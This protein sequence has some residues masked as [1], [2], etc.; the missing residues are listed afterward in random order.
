MIISSSAIADIIKCIA[1]KHPLETGG[2]LI[3]HY[4]TRFCLATVEVAS[5]PPPDSI[6][7]RYSF[8]RG[9]QGLEALLKKQKKKKHYYLGEW[10]SHPNHAPSASATDIWQMNKFATK[11]MYGS[12]S[13]LLLIVGGNLKNGLQWQA[14]LH[15]RWRLPNYLTLI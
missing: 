7:G 10:H 6:H 8:E 3:G 11:K 9:T 5:A 2:I 14:S 1:E 4:D 13:P 15:K 12:T